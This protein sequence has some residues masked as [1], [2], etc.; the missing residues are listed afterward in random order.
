MMSALFNKI[1]RII[2]VSFVVWFV[3]APLFF[4]ALPKTTHAQLDFTTAAGAV[5]GVALSCTDVVGK[6]IKAVMSKL[7]GSD[8]GGGNEV[9]VG[10][11]GSRD[12]LSSANQKERCEDGIA[13]AIAK[14]A[15][16]QV[17]KGIVDWINTGF[18]GS[19]LYLR[20]PNLFY[21]NLFQIQTTGVI[22]DIIG[23]ESPFGPAVAQSLI[24]STQNYFQHQANYS[25]ADILDGLGTTPQRFQANFSDGGWGALLA[26][27][28][29]PAN[30][31][32]GLYIA[33]S[34]ELGVRTQNLRIP[35]GTQIRQELQQSGGFLNVRKCVETKEVITEVGEPVFDEDGLIIEIPAEESI[36]QCV[37]YETTTPGTAVASKLTGALGSGER[38]L[39][40]ADDIN[41]SL[42]AVFDALLNNLVQKGLSSLSGALDGGSTDDT[43]SLFSANTLDSVGGNEDWYYDNIQGDVNM[44]QLL[45]TGFAPEVIEYELMPNDPLPPSSPSTQLTFIQNPDGTI[46]TVVQTSPFVDLYG[47]SQM[48]IVD[49][50]GIES[51]VPNTEIERPSFI[52]LQDIVRAYTYNLEQSADIISSEIIPELRVLDN[53]LPEPNYGWETRVRGKMDNSIQAIYEETSTEKFGRV[54]TKILDPLGFFSGITQGQIA[55]REAAK[56]ASANKLRERTMND[57]QRIKFDIQFNNLDS[58]YSARALINKGPRYIDLLSEYH[59][60]IATQKSN[61]RRLEQIKSD[62]IA[63]SQNPQEYLERSLL[64]LL[65]SLPVEDII[66]SSED[67]LLDLI[68]MRD[69]EIVDAT[70]SAQAEMSNMTSFLQAQT[71]ENPY[72]PANINIPSTLHELN[73]VTNPWAIYKIDAG[74]VHADPIATLYGVQSF[75]AVL[76]WLAPLEKVYYVEEDEEYFINRYFEEYHVTGF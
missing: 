11:S 40:L 6:G 75:G 70:V 42:G 27:Y 49:Q 72:A 36:E 41:E 68:D 33:S 60:E 10:D 54:V 21:E 69:V 20:D 15:L 3:V 59:S 17:T 66:R 55:K 52:T 26:L 22:N 47:E 62:Y 9:P 12:K 63:Q 37:R 43:Q 48:M 56:L 39:E 73:L 58:A 1:R 45:I 25:Y 32:T 29:S 67:D 13:Y 46:S 14:T 35:I 30:T 74:L 51:W 38:Q 4:I 8:E 16:E 50:N 5:G 76:N 71:L 28:S 18:E 31:P 19:P 23:G 7:S 61:L 24:R 2:F 44:E 57:I 65:Q 64:R 34:R 53:L